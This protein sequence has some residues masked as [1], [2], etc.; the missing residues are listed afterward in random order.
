MGVFSVTSVIQAV[1]FF[2]FGEEKI[3][4]REHGEHGEKC[5]ASNLSGLRDLCGV[6]FAW[7]RRC[8]AVPSGVM[9]FLDYGYA[10]RVTSTAKA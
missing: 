4:H 2:V 5:F 9:S 7:L 10:S 6:I 1:N 8:R 3:H